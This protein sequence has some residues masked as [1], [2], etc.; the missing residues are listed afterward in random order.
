MSNVFPDYI[1]KMLPIGN[2]SSILSM[3]KEGDVMSLSEFI[4]DKRTEKDWSQRELAAASSISN[5]EISRI[6][7][8]KRKEPSPTVLKAIAKALNVPIEEMLMQADVI[9]KGKAVVDQIL[10]EHG[11]ETVSG[12]QTSGFSASS[13][14]LTVDDLSEEEIED[15]KKYISFI[16]S[17]RNRV[18]GGD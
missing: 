11:N 5:A 14:Y 2:G 12:I 15:V 7:G 9:E 13:S 18:G 4:R 1:K 17:K 6:E 16:K 10:E 3:R 8:G